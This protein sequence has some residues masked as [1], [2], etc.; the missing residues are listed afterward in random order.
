M[1]R[2]FPSLPMREYIE[3]AFFYSK[4]DS[5][6]PGFTLMIQVSSKKIVI[7]LLV[8]AVIVLAAWIGYVAFL[9]H[10]GMAQSE[11][12]D[13]HYSISLSY[14]TTITNVTILLPVPLL[15]GTPVLAETFVHR[16][17]HGIPDDWDLSIEEVGGT[18]M[19]A[20]RAAK[21]VP[22][23]HGY[24]VAIEPG[25]SPLPT[26]IIPRTEYSAETPILYPFNI[27][28]MLPVNRTIETRDPV[29]NEPVFAPEEKFIPAE[30]S[31]RPYFQGKEYTHPVLVYVSFSSERPVS[32]S[33][34]SSISGTN[35]IWRG[36]WVFNSYDDSIAVELQESPGW[37]EAGGILR[38][39]EGVYYQ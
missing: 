20:I 25:Q 29:G 3:I 37:I 19:L 26:T 7:S 23:Y 30:G 14:T 10:E 27:G 35:S 21:M 11:R 12:H 15:E 17:V 18:P 2:A 8:A 32:F 6:I 1:I 5:F 28:T 13:Y 39:G 9:F 4:E 24:P 33:L 36:G 31:T 22:A 16:S 38:T 34:Q